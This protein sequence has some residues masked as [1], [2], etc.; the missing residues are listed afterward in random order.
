MYAT[1]KEKED[2]HLRGSGCT[3]KGLEEGKKRNDVIIY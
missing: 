3:W 1:I 2:I